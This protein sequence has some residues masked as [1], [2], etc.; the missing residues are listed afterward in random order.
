MHWLSFIYDRLQEFD[1]SVFF[2]NEKLP[3]TVLQNY[4]LSSPT[5]N[6]SSTYICYQITRF[7][8]NCGFQAILKIF[9]IMYSNSDRAIIYENIFCWITQ[10]RLSRKF[11]ID[12]LDYETMFDLT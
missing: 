3:V 7:D 2:V 4:I 5:L 6:L 10:T 9:I 1:Y 8:L 12:R 11:E